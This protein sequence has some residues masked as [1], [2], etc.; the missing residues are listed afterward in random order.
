MIL[1][2][3]LLFFLT[4]MMLVVALFVGLVSW[5]RR[6][7]GTVRKVVIVVLAWLGA[8]GVTL[9]TVSA[10]SRAPVLAR[11]QEHCFD[12]MCY[13]IKGSTEAKTLGTNP[14]NGIFTIVDL[15]LRNASSRTAQKPSNP[16]LWL[17]GPDGREFRALV[18]GKGEKAGQPV[19]EGQ[20]WDQR[21]DPG[22]LEEEWVAFDIPMDIVSPQL[23]ISEGPDFPT[24]GIIGDENSFF[25]AKT[26]FLLQP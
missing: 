1:I 23:V 2:G 22:G 7:M 13:S 3:T 14:A 21:T 10:T 5:M 11:G 15:Q 18:W 24:K 6:R 19:G 9:L 20:L 12:E 17:V 25:H 26:T 8:Y 4:I 16:Q